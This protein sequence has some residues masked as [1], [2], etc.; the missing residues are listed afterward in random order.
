MYSKTNWE[1]EVEADSS[2]AENQ[3]H[4]IISSS[5]AW[6]IC[7]DLTDEE[8]TSSGLKPTVSA[9]Q[10]KALIEQLTGQ[11]QLYLLLELQGQ[12]HA[13]DAM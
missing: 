10:V 4:E 3:M 7:E 5:D 11:S 1:V 8:I 2:V 6:T 13:A 9:R 12:G